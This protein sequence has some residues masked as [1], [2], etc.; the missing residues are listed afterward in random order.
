MRAEL[1]RR[2]EIATW[3]VP[4]LLFTLTTCVESMSWNQLGAFTPLYLRELGVAARDVPTWTGAMSSLGWLLA[5][6]LAPFW[7]VWADRYSRKAVIVRSALGEGIIFGGWALAHDPWTALFFRCLNGFILGNTGVMLAVQASTTPARRLGLAVG[8]VSAGAPLGRAFGPAL[9]SLLIHLVDIRGML[10]VDSVLSFAAGGL[11]T[12]ALREPERA[13]PR[14]VAVLRLLRDAVGEIAGHALV[15]RLFVAMT[16]AMTGMWITYPFVPI[17]VGRQAGG[18]DVPTAVGLV[19]SGTAAAQAMASP[20]WGRLVD[21]FGHVSVLTLTSVV[22]ALAAA[23]AGF[24]AS[25]GALAA[26]LVVYS[27]FTAAIQTSVMAL[28]ARVVSPERRGAVLGQVLFP[29]YVAG[30]VGPPIGTLLFPAGQPG[31]FLGS[32]LLTLAP[33][34]LLTGSRRS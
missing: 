6:P 1:D 28:L 32:A 14:H 30:L 22:A 13:R 2:E 26:A 15:R 9:G 5:L 10:L 23:A 12:L 33:I 18:M 31:V 17:F 16:L 29:F 19:V 27:A 11:L 8:V 3:A 4:M 21:R 20:F 34:A 7:G 25:I 24:T